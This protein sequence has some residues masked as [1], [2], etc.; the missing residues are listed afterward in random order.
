[1]NMDTYREFAELLAEE[2]YFTQGTFVNFWIK[3]LKKE[4]KKNLA[5][6][7]FILILNELDKLFHLL[8]MED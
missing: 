7:Q 2:D 8:I 1:M 3:K 4:K 6:K 5:Q